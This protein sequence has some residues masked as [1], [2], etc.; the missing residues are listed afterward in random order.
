MEIRIAIVPA[1]IAVIALSMALPANAANQK[2]KNPRPQRPKAEN[3]VV[4]P[5]FEVGSG[6]V[7]TGWTLVGGGSWAPDVAHSGELAISVIGKGKDSSYWRADLNLKP[8]T[9]YALGFWARGE[10]KGGGCIISGP[11]FANQDYALEPEW[12]HYESVFVTPP[13]FHPAQDYLRFGQWTVDGII[14]FDDITLRE[15]IPVHVRRGGVELGSGELVSGTRYEASLV[16][17]DPGG[18][19]HRPLVAFNA[20]WNTNRWRMGEGNF[21]LYRHELGDVEQRSA[22]VAVDLGFY[23][24]GSCIVEASNDGKTFVPAG[25]VGKESRTLPLP[26]QLF[27]ARA[28]WVRLSAAAA[29]ERKGDSAP[30]SFQVTGYRYSAELSRQLPDIA[31]QTTYL[32]VMTHEK[33]LA[34]AVVSLGELRPA[35]DNKAQLVLDSARAREVKVSVAVGSARTGKDVSLKPGRT[36]V[37]IPYSVMKAGA[38]PIVLRIAEAGTT[39]YEARASVTVPQLLA[40]DYGRQ[41][42][43]GPLPLWWCGATYKVST[44]RPLP[45]AKGKTVRIAAARNE[46]EPFQLVVRPDRDVKNVTITAGPLSG[47]KGAKIAP[48]EIRLVAYVNVTH[49]TDSAGMPGLWPDPLPRY[50]GPFD[51]AAGRN[52]PIWLT[53]CVPPDA[54]PGIYRGEVTISAD[55]HSVTAPVELRVWNFTLPKEPS[56]RSGFGFSS[57]WVARYENLSGDALTATIDKYY[58]AFQSH[59]ISPYT[60]MRA[61]V[62]NFGRRWEGGQLVSRDAHEGNKCLHILDSD[63]HRAVDAH[64]GGRIPVNPQLSYR[65][66]L[67]FRGAQPA[68]PVQATLAQF[69][70]NGQWL[71]GRNIDLSFD[72]GQEWRKADVDVAGRITPDTHAV[73]IVLRPC[74]WTE[75]GKNTGEA[76]FDDIRLTAAGSDENLVPNP[77]FEEEDE[78]KVT[79]DWTDFDRDAAYYLDELGFNSFSM[80]VAGLGGGTFYEASGAEIAGT[81]A[82]TPD[83]KQVMARYLGGIQQHLEERGWLRKAYIYWFDEPGGEQFEYVRGGMETLKEFAPKLNRF[84]T[85]RPV[86]P[87]YGAVNTWCVPVGAYDPKKCHERQKAGDE[88]WWYLCCGPHAPWVGLFIDHPAVDFRTWLWMS[89]KYAVTGILIW[90]TNWWTSPTAFPDPALQNPWDDPMSYVSGYGVAPGTRN[91]WGNGDGRLWYPTNRRVDTDRTPH[92][93]GPVPSIRVELLREGIE[94]YEY[95]QILRG[96]ADKPGAP[97][98]AKAL[99]EIPKEI[100]ADLTHYNFDPEPMMRHRAKVAAMIERLSR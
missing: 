66:G 43:P 77:G 69:D 10:N 45:K 75:D 26:A 31:G 27:P 25:E 68:Q 5:S 65:F 72:A 1:L 60:P 21:V 90:H 93:D 99:L 53:V 86:E 59:R 88:I 83:Y 24:A 3:L 44:E 48:P 81:K 78:V 47:P 20:A 70:A 100:I 19:Y 89:H 28:I 23:E 29:A 54:A 91:Y 46:Y 58:R 64:T 49:P 2:P 35:A 6:D 57:E 62:V 94:D 63:E 11:S 85:V 39:L 92:T 30:G 8:A 36:A 34:I 80:P 15:A 17:D 13:Q 22:Q 42:S 67:T 16:G 12:R 73:Q 87:L 55:G 50:T 97:P 74:L 71:S 7:P 61:P 51:A 18:N 32:Q 98:E 96:L 33:D 14:C 84:L 56:I 41:V 37:T 79:F 52:Q 4:N 40:A 38:S 95:F 82:G 9:T 76:W